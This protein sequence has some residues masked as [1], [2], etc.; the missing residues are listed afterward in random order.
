MLTINIIDMV[1]SCYQDVIHSQHTKQY[2]KA[3]SPIQFAYEFGMLSISPPRRTGVTTAAVSLMRLAKYRG[4]ILI[5]PKQTMRSDYRSLFVRSGEEKLFNERVFA[6]DSD[7]GI[8]KIARL[9]YAPERHPL[10][11]FDEATRIKESLFDEAVAHLAP[12]TDFFVKLR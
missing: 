6:L 5:V 10:V 4:S 7:Y 2:K 12:Y 11:I 8:T 3:M 9:G 1:D